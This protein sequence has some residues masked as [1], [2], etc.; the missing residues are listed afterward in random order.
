MEMQ[1]F[2]DDTTELIKENTIEEEEY[3]QLT[4]ENIGR[5]YRK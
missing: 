3:E 5:V 2:V 1:I 4:G